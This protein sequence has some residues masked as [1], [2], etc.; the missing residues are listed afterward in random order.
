MGGKDPDEIYVIFSSTKVMNLLI[1]GC[2]RFCFCFFSF[3]NA[4]SARVAPKAN[5]F[6]TEDLK[7]T[8]IDLP[9]FFMSLASP[10]TPAHQPP[11]CG[12]RCHKAKPLMLAEL[13]QSPQVEGWSYAT[14][15][16]KGQCSSIW[17]VEND[18]L[19]LN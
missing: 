18:Q 4:T 11:H 5:S 13:K 8:T 6:N 7:K 2:H 3:W 10:P 15:T 1:L 17:L 14:E 16:F 19:A 9:L 12:F